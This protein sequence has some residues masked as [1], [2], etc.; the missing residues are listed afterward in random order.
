MTN[1]E[2]TLRDA[3]QKIVD[4]RFGWDGDC[5]VKTIAEDA[6]YAFDQTLV[7]TSSTEAPGELP[8]YQISE[9]SVDLVWK[10]V[11]RGYYESFS[12]E[13]RLKRVLCSSK[14]MSADNPKIISDETCKEEDGCPTEMAVLKRFWRECQAALA[15]RATAA[16]SVDNEQ[17]GKFAER[18]KRS[19]GTVSLNE[20]PA[21]TVAQAYIDAH[22][23]KVEATDPSLWFCG[24]CGKS[25]KEACSNRP[26]GY[27]AMQQ[28]ANAAQ[29]VTGGLT[30][31][32]RATIKQIAD[33]LDSSTQQVQTGPDEWSHA[34]Q[35]DYELA[36]AAA[37]L[38]AIIAALKDPK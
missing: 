26:C 1:N 2:K 34:S 30:D 3:L 17:G 36:Q 19:E 27:R 12:S 29:V 25:V 21:E 5:G 13:A 9:G 8:V 22:S 10:D 28:K 31:A 7:A 6:I 32:Q 11:S 33:W 16:G 20:T 38:T 23:G 35:F 37:E 15:Q 14:H 4:T 18:R 24:D